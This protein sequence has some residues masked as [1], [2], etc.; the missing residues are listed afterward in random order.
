M[1]IVHVDNDVDDHNNLDQGSK[2][3]DPN[4][5]HCPLLQT[6]TIKK[7]LEHRMLLRCHI[8]YSCFHAIRAELNSWDKNH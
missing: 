1:L 6:T 3:M 4:P 8:V 7:I 5:A 2:S